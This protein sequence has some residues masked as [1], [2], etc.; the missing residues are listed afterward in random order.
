MKTVVITGAAGAV[1]TAVAPLL[2]KRYRLR[3]TDRVRPSWCRPDQEFVAADLLD[4]NALRGALSGAD[5]VIHLGAFGREGTWEQILRAN[6]Q[7]TYNLFEAARFASVPRVV[8]AS[9]VH[10]VGY[11]PRARRIGVDEHVRPDSRYGLSKCF[12]EACASLFADKFG[13][14]VLVVRIG[15]AAP[16]P[17]DERRLSIWISARDLAQLFEIGLEHPD[18]HYEIVYGASGNRRTWWDNSSAF[19][20][21]YRPLDDSEEYAAELLKNGPIEDQNVPGVL[22]QGGHFVALD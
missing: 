2:G 7:G 14:R 21:G 22:H 11:Y 1:G 18:L 8:Y 20:L 5:G 3:L 10:A 9:S 19:H 4:V 15:N 6:I 12:G 16:K 13:L 17:V